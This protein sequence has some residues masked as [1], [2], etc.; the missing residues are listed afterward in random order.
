MHERNDAGF[1]LIELLVAMT[2]L[3]IGVVALVGVIGSLTMVTTHQRGLSGTD[4]VVRDWGEAVKQKALSNTN[5][6]K[7]AQW[8]DLDPGFAM[9]TGYA[10]ASTPTV[11][12][13]IPSLTN[14]LSGSFT[15][16]RAL[17]TNTAPSGTPGYYENVC[18]TDTRPECDPGVQR[19]TLTV[20]STD[21]KTRG[22]QTTT[23][24]LVRRGNR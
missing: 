13:W 18:G 7:C 5:P 3:S 19:V 17:C 9:P 2:I 16:N 20:K 14:P 10:M 6:A 24:V 1:T 12:Y 22:G 8:S 21:P 11:E 15:T 4:T 23:Q